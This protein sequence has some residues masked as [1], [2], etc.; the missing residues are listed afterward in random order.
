MTSPVKIKVVKK[1]YMLIG[2]TVDQIIFIAK[3]RIFFILSLAILYV[4]AKIIYL[5]LKNCQRQIIRIL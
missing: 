2:L 4:V 3:F 5:I 1:T